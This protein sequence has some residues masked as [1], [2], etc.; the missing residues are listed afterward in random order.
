M[1]E[2]GPTDGP[3]AGFLLADLGADVIK[4]EPVPEG[5]ATRRLP[6]FGIGFFGYLNRNKRS[7]V[8]N[9]KTA[10]DADVVVENYGPGTMERLRCGSG[11]LAA[12]K[13]PLVYLALKASWRART[14]GGRRWTRWSSSWPA[15][16]T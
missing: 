1:L 13:P 4:G 12:Q 15:S 7:F 5:D 6:G 11:Q 10:A 16:R 9:L 14:R 8:V 3:T 2:V